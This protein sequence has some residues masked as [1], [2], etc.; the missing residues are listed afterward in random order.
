MPDYSIT[1][2]DAKAMILRYQNDPTPG[3][4]IG[5]RLPIQAVQDIIKQPGCVSIRYYFAKKDTGENTIVL[6]GEDATG[7]AMSDGAL[8][9]QWLPCPPWCPQNSLDK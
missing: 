2:P 1:R 3:T 8:S 6:V 7:T 5:G 9:E 4:I